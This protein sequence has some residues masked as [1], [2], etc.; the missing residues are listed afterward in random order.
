[1]ALHGMFDT[2]AGLILPGNAPVTVDTEPQHVPA[3]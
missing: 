1:M 3:A 2:A